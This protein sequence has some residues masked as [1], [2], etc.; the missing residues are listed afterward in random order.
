M[1]NYYMLGGDL[2]LNLYTLRE[3]FK[4]DL[5]Q[6][7]IL[8]D[9]RINPTAHGR[10][11]TPMEVESLFFH[12]DLIEEVLRRLEHEETLFIPVWGDNDDDDDDD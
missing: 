7:I 8:P 1:R 4:F 6:Y 5:R 9:R 11:L 10:Q 12:G 2:M 3:T